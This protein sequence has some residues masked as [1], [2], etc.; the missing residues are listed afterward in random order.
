MGIGR[1]VSPGRDGQRIPSISGFF[2]VEETH[3][4]QVQIISLMIS[5]F[6]KHLNLVLTLL[7]VKLSRNSVLFSLQLTLPFIPLFHPVP[8]PSSPAAWHPVCDGP[9]SDLLLCRRP[10]VSSQVFPPALSE[11]YPPGVLVVCAP[12]LSA[13]SCLL[14]P[15]LLSRLFSRITMFFFCVFLSAVRVPL[16]GPLTVCQLHWSAFFSILHIWKCVITPRW[17]FSFFFAL[18]PSSKP[19]CPFR[20]LEDNPSPL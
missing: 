15:L 19:G 12:S 6:P 4:L 7:N 18:S 20:A 5:S 14:S 11:R 2:G 17:L 3:Y 16:S 9:L 10:S 13:F 8:C 1:S